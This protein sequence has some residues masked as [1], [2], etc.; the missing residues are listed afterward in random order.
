MRAMKHRKA[1]CFF[2]SPYDRKNHSKI[3]NEIL[4]NEFTQDSSWGFRMLS[5]RSNCLQAVYIEK[6]TYLEKVID[7]FGVTSEF[8]RVSYHQIEFQLSTYPPNILI[9]QPPRNYRKLI[10]QLAQFVDYKVVIESKNT[11][12]FDWVD[13]LMKSGMEGIVTKVNVDQISYDKLTTG[14]L[15]LIGHHDVRE[16]VH[17]LLPET[18]FFIKNAKIAFNKTVNLPDVEIFANGRIIFKSS[19]PIEDFKTFYDT[20]FQLTAK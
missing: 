10:N 13:L 6:L 16:R 12:V 3:E 11:K 2:C 20:F 19:I 17:Q 18:S 1:Q 9:F 8:E 7:P 14:K 4:Q 5:R 15:T